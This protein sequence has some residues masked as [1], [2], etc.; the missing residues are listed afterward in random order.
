M[1]AATRDTSTRSTPTPIAV[2]ARRSEAEAARGGAERLLPVGMRRLVEHTRLAHAPG[3]PIECVEGGHERLAARGEPGGDRA[4]LGAGEKTAAAPPARHPNLAGGPFDLP[5][6]RG[7]DALTGPAD[8]A[9]P[10]AEPGAPAH[11]VEHPV[12]LLAGGGAARLAGQLHGA[13]REFLAD[14]V[15]WN[16]RLL[17]ATGHQDPAER[18]RDLGDA[19]RHRD[20]H[21]RA[22]RATRAARPVRASYCATK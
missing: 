20:L 16:P 3:H 21:R 12:A 17:Q 18:R 4:L 8:C 19:Q 14:V 13:R 11:R 1:I 9:F 15:E 2:T 6:E 7:R 5:V 10:R 22:H